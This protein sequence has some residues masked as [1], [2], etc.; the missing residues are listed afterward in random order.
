MPVASPA[1]AEARNPPPCHLANWCE[2]APACHRAVHWR[3][4]ACVP[5][6]VTL[7]ETRSISAEAIARDKFDA[8]RSAYEERLAGLLGQVRK[9]TANGCRM[10]P[11]LTKP[12]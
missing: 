5:S 3:K 6:Q 8:L 11:L 10:H 12:A 9:L 2:Q 7:V 4:H 1:R